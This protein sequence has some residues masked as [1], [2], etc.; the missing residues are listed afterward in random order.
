[1]EH[2]NTAD[3]AAP[4][5]AYSHGVVAGDLLFTAGMGPLDPVTAPSS[6][7]PS[8]TRRQR[9]SE[10]WRRSSGFAAGAWATW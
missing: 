5:G 2:L 7:K 6:A 1:M 3:A 9:S 8:R 10:T 4:R